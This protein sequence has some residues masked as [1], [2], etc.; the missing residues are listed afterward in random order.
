M[1]HLVGTNFLL[2]PKPSRPAER[3]FCI[4]DTGMP[5]SYSSIIAVVALISVSEYAF[6]SF[7]SDTIFPASTSFIGALGPKGCEF[8][9]N[10]TFISGFLK[11]STFASIFLS[12]SAKSLISSSTLPFSTLCMFDLYMPLTRSDLYSTILGISIPRHISG[13][14]STSVFPKTGGTIGEMNTFG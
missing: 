1:L 12:A 5:F 4:F 10:T 9:S 11:N 13:I 2:F 7:L 6:S 3:A 8:S 14:A